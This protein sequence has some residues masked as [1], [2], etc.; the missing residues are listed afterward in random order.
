MA[1]FLF[2][3]AFG[4]IML[5]RTSWYFFVSSLSEDTSSLGSLVFVSAVSIKCY[6]KI[7]FNIS[8]FSVIYLVYRTN[9]YKE[10]GASC[11]FNL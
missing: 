1:I 7:T 11:L 3:V 8:Y 2:S 9:N 10:T 6:A 5:E 4:M